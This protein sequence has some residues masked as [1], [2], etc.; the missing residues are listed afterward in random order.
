MTERLLTKG[1]KYTAHVLDITPAADSF[2]SQ[3]GEGAG[4]RMYCHFIEIAVLGFPET[5]K[6]QWCN[7]N[8]T[9][10]EFAKGDDIKIIC[11]ST[12]IG[13]GMHTIK[14]EHLVATKIQKTT[15]E[16]LKNTGA[17]EKE[18]EKFVDP[19]VKNTNPMIGGTL[20]SVCLGH[21]VQFH[22]DR[23]TSTIQDAMMDAVFLEE[24][25]KKRF[26]ND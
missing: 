11:T 7:S 2:I 15:Q 8:Q 24:D 22:K 5:H 4:A 10:T 18:K 1:F 3:K 13:K 21:A 25:Y 26:G 19:G 23:K 9:V 17:S 20:W 14:F 6:V 16:F 12:S